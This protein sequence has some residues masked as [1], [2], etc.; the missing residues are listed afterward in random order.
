[1]SRKT[2]IGWMSVGVILT[3]FS[4]ALTLKLRDG[5]K[6]IARE[7][8]PEA[9][10]ETPLPPIGEATPGKPA[11]EIPKAPALE[12]V[13]PPQSPPDLSSPTPTFVPNARMR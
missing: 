1:M 9:Y 2:Q 13:S 10:A 6:L 7:D 5:D 3:L 12:S 4:I 8:D 11:E